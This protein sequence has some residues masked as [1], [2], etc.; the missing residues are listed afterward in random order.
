ME[1]M[2]RGKTNVESVW[3]T[4]GDSSQ[5]EAGKGRYATDAFGEESVNFI[6]E[7]RPAGSR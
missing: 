5:Y 1:V 3:A 6:T 7:L 2:M 4:Q